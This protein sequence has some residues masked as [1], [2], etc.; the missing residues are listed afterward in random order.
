M[1]W[2]EKLLV[3]CLHKKDSISLQLNKH[4]P[5]K[6]KKF[7][8]PIPNSYVWDHIS[9]IKLQV[10]HIRTRYIELIRTSDTD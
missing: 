6:K 2:L 1:N 8:I 3:F 7:D 9:L 10:F 5:E 4:R